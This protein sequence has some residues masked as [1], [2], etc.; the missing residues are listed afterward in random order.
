MI[1]CHLKYSMF[2]ISFCVTFWFKIWTSLFIR[3]CECKIKL[4]QH[5]LSKKQRC[6]LGLHFMLQISAHFALSKH[7]MHFVVACK[8][9]ISWCG[10][11]A[12]N[13]K[14]LSFVHRVIIIQLVLCT[15]YLI[16]LL[17]S[18]RKNVSRQ[19]IIIFLHKKISLIL[20]LSQYF[21]WMKRRKTY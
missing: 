15:E 13:L 5:Q 8:Q 9:I 10:R 1:S 4:C 17:C 19:K 11:N 14:N 16:D 6:K 21:C 3:Y 18:H 2:I 7:D 20:Y 12:V